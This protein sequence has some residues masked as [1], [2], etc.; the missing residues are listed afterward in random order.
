M[1]EKK[2]VKGLLIVCRLIIGLWG[3]EKLI[4]LSWINCLIICN[5]NNKLRI[6][7]NLK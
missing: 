6:K 4:N 5:K 3:L 1:F 7:R 2:L